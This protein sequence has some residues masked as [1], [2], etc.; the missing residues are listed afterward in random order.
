VLWQT[1]HACK[2]SLSAQKPLQAISMRE[3]SR[4]LFPRSGFTT[5]DLVATYEQIGPVL[6][7][8][9]AARPLTLKHFPDGMQ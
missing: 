4:I 9:L 3:A 6:L 7:P 5:D 2:T 8:H 1:L